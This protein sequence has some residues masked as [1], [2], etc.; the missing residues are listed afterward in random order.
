MIAPVVEIFNADIYRDGGS[1]SFC[2]HSDDGNWYE[3][4]VRVL[5]RRFVVTGYAE[6]VLYLKSVNDRNVVHELSW[7]EAID[8]VD[9]LEY[10]N[11]RFR[12]LLEVVGRRG[13]VPGN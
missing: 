9:Q 3:F 11:Q 5:H 7:D 12:E 4:H 2:Y 6:P 8:F 13:Q 1:R 10:D